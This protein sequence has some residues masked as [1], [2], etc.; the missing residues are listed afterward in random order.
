M[1]FRFEFSRMPRDLNFLKYRIRKKVGFGIEEDRRA[2]ESNR[3]KKSRVS[4]ISP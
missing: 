2:E 4:K 3:R 1:D